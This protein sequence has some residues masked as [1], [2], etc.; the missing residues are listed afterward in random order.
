MP[1]GGGNSLSC[2]DD[3]FR[4][5]IEKISKSAAQRLLNPYIIQS[6]NHVSHPRHSFFAPN[7]E[8]K[9][10]LTKAQPPAALGILARALKELGKEG[11]ELLNGALESLPRE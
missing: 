11:R 9:V 1:R 6:F 5:P 7:S 10:R 2:V 3:I 4:R 8:A